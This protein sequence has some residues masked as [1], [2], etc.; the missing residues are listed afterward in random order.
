MWF[1]DSG[2][3]NE[4]SVQSRSGVTNYESQRKLN[5]KFERWQL[6]FDV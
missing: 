1:R 5:E 4:G 2:Q 6:N 3:T